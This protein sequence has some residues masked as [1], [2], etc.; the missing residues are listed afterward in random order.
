MKHFLP[1]FL[2]FALSFSATAQQA[3][4]P[5]AASSNERTSG[6]GI[7]LTLSVSPLYQT[8]VH[9][10]QLIADTLV[11]AIFDQQCAALDS[12]TLFG[13]NQNSGFVV[14]SNGFFD[15]EKI[16]RITLDDPTTFSISSVFFFVGAADSTIFNQ[17]IVANIY[18]DLDADGNFGDF[19]GAS[20]TLLIGDFAGN[21]G[22]AS[23]GF[24]QINFSTPVDLE[25]ATSFLVGIDVSDVYNSTEAGDIGFAHTDNGCGDGTNL[26]EIF[27]TDNGL[28]FNTIFG[29]WNGLNI[30]MFVGVIIDREPATSVRTPNADFS[31]SA[32]PNPADDQLNVQ[33]QAPASGSYTTRLVSPNGQT[34]RTQLTS[35]VR[36]NTTVRLDVADLP[37]GI[38]LFQV[39]SAAGVETGRV[40]IR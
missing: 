11:P 39:E 40:V 2:L 26:I 1:L 17:K 6:S 20:D 21:L 19:L 37:A 3:E 29:N 9:N 14:G 15:F 31:A 22:P 28:S 35:A 16:Q 13:I 23:V 12:L 10:K 33:F 36:G 24:S 5:R 34:V 18:T 30:E 38:Y 25:A 8:G 32:F 7:D 27:P 4:L